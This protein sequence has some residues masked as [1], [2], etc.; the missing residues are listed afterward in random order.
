EHTLADTTLA[1]KKLGFKARITLEKG[2]EML[3]DYYRKNPKEMP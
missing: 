2:I 3:V 1:E